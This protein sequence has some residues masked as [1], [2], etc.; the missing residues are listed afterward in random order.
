MEKEMS[1]VEQ[2]DAKAAFGPRTVEHEYHLNL[3]PILRQLAASLLIST[4]QAGSGPLATSRWL[5][6]CWR[7]FQ[8][9][10]CCENSGLSLHARSSESWNLSAPSG[11]FGGGCGALPED[12][13]NRTREC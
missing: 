4:Y 10:N 8:R 5:A 7:R 1:A 9:S 11:R 13:G 3:P 6:L 12:P 2:E